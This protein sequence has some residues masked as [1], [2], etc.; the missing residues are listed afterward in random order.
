MTAAMNARELKARACIAFPIHS[1]N[2]QELT[3]ATHYARFNSTKAGR[4]PRRGLSSTSFGKVFM[5]HTVISMVT[6]VLLAGTAFA[7][8]PAAGSSSNVS[9]LP[10]ATFEL[11]AGTVAAGIG[12]TWGHGEVTYQ[13]VKHKFKISGLSVVDV[14]AANISAVGFVYHLSKLQDLTGNYVAASAGLTIAGGG[15][16]VVLKNEH[17][18]F[19]KVAGTSQ[20]LRFDLAGSGVNVKL[21]D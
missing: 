12:Y 18:V 6:C 11:T 7:D 1:V 13:G 21:E 20:G 19:V 3:R 8:D 16:A 15:D 5:R 14:G 4:W 9:D 10:D 17:G 2:V